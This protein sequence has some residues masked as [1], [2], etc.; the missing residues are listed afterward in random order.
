[1]VSKRGVL[2]AAFSCSVGVVLRVK[3]GLFGKSKKKDPK[4]VVSTGAFIGYCAKNSR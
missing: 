2:K 1:M 4:K 3:M